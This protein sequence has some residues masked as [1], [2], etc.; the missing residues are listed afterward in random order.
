[1][2][3]KREGLE[4]ANLGGS[5]RLTPESPIGSFFD[6]E[7]KK[8][9]E[10]TTAETTDKPVVET[11]VEDTLKT[12]EVPTAQTTVEPT[13][14][15][16]GKPTLENDEEN[17]TSKVDSVIANLPT[18]KEEPATTDVTDVESAAPNVIAKGG[19]LRIGSTVKTIKKSDFTKLNENGLYD[20]QKRT[21]ENAREFNLVT[22]TLNLRPD[23]L[24]ILTAVSSDEAGNNIKNIQSA[25]VNNGIIRE[26]IAIGVL[27]ED[28][29]TEFRDYP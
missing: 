5:K 23:L 16:V 8:I 29:L 2:A 28:S 19:K 25:I 21:P 3:R 7:I 20:L 17:F 26:L 14:E 15:T 22:K 18:I 12:T 27:D 1:M 13:G 4:G 6:D 24:A 11:T 10:E 9:N